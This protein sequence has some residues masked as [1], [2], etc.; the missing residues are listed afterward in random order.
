LPGGTSGE[1][2]RLLA[3]AWGHAVPDWV[4]STGEYADHLDTARRRYRSAERAA[5]DEV[6]PG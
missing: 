6:R 2:A 3:E 5:A 4:R 1:A